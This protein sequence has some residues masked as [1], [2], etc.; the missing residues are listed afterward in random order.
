MPKAVSGS[1]CQGAAFAAFRYVPRHVGDDHFRE[2]GL[3]HRA[4]LAESRL[5]YGLNVASNETFGVG[6][7]A[8]QCEQ[9]FALHGAI[10]IEQGDL[11]GRPGQHRTATLTELGSRETSLVEHGEDA[12]NDCR[13]GIGAP[14]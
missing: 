12:A 8:M 9:S 11:R 10:D 13:I 7:G 2:L 6:L 3:H 5:E 1:S 4:S 14:G